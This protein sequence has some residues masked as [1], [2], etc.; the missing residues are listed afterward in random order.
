MSVYNAGQYLGQAIESI[1]RQSFSDFEFIIIEDCSTDDSLRVIQHYAAQ[2]RRIKLIQKPENKR[3]K[4]FIENLNLGLKYAK[5]KYIARMDADDISHPDRFEKQV[6]FLDEN[7]ETFMVGSAINFIDE[8]NEFIKTLKALPD[9][10]AIQKQMPKKIA[11]YHPAIMFRN[12]PNIA[13]RDKIY[14][15]EDY[16]LYLRLMLEGKKFANF[17]EALLDYRLLNSSISRKDG[18]FIRTLFVEKM[19][20]FWRERK[21]K[22]TDSYEDFSPETL[23]NILKSDEVSSKDDMKLALSI[24]TKYRYTKEFNALMTKYNRYY[25]SDSYIDTLKILNRLLIVAAK[26]FF[27]ISQN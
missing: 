5:G 1:L 13:Y 24:A 11:M 20:Q 12:E 15:C 16:D 19:K 9:N 3:M 22:G 2:D 21:Q 25:P 27:K 4:G 6:K 18:N 17:E 7:P 8:N 14:Y 23:L 10:E 26:L